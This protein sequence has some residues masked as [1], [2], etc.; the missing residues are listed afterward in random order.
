MEH[1]KGHLDIV[2]AC[3][4]D[5]AQYGDTFLGM[6]WTK[7]QEDAD[8]RYRVMLEVIRE[9]PKEHITLLDFG[10]GASHLYEYMLNHGLEHIGY[11][12]LDLSEKYLALAKRKFPSLPYYHLDVLESEGDLPVFDYVIMNG[13]FNYKGDMSYEEMLAYFQRLLSTV[14]N[15]SKVGLAF[16]VMSKQVDWE[17]DDLFHLPFDEVAS[18]L[19]KHL[20]R[21]F[22]IRHDY[23]LYEY[24]V[25]LYR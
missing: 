11:S 5:L 20:S 14:F 13:I 21:H 10:C 7:R 22:V 1:H 3:E 4:A 2:A 17:R 15:K 24:T 9:Q 8:T 23:R 25:Y 16:N 19:T 6:G 18:F 12:G